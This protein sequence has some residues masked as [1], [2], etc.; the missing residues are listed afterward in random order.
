LKFQD[1]YALGVIMDVSDTI[2]AMTVSLLFSGALLMSVA[3]IFR[4]YF[5]AE[6]DKLP[7]AIIATVILVG[8]A[9]F[10]TWSKW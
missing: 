9:A 5:T 1:F 6:E 8:F 4:H 2:F 7:V 10:V 3:A